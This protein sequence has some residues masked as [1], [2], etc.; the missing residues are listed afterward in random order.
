MSIAEAD[1]RSFISGMANTFSLL[2]DVLQDDEALAGQLLEGFVRGD[3][4]R[5]EDAFAQATIG[6]EYE[7]PAGDDGAHRLS[8]RIGRV[9]AVLEVEE[10]LAV[11]PAE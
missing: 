8:F 6:M 5:V 9:A 4:A 7:G 1:V 2:R 10:A 11:Q 3:K